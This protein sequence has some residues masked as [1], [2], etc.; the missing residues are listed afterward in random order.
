METQDRKTKSTIKILTIVGIVLILALIGSLVYFFV[1]K[2][3]KGEEPDLSNISCGCY[4]VDPAVTN[5][6]VGPSRG[7]YFKLNT[8][9]SDKVCSAQCD[10]NDIKDNLLNTSTPK[11]DFVSCPVRT[12][13]DTRCENII[14]KD[15]NDKII[16]GRIQPGDEI[17]A[18]AIFEKST[19]TDYVFIINSEDTTPDQVTGNKITKKIIPPSDKSSIEISATAKDTKGDRINSSITCR[20]VV[21]IE[22]SATTAV[23][24]MTA[25]TEQQSDGKTKITN[26]SISVGQINSSNIQIRFTFEPE[27]PTLQAVDGITVDSLKGSLEMSKLDLY[28]PT[29]FK[30]NSFNVLNDHLGSLKIMAEVF[31][32]EASIGSTETTITFSDS[33]TTQPP[34]EQPITDDQKS[35]FTVAKTVSPACVERVAGE[36]SATYTITINNT[37]TA[38]DSL[39]SIKDKLPLGFTYV[40]N[41]SVING[42]ATPDSGLVTVN[43]IGDSQEIIWEPTTPYTLASGGTMTIVFQANATP[44][45]TTGQN[46]NEVILNPIEI[47][48]DPATLRTQVYVVVAQDCENPTE[49]ETEIPQTGIFDNFITRILLGIFLLVI[50]WMVY[51]RPAG[52]LLSENILKSKIYGEYELTKYKFINPK[53]YFEEKILRK[54]FKGKQ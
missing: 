53:K 38:A 52:D 24:G 14:L 43:Q 20:R 2:D 41:S 16:T 7:F 32:N 37:K 54:R 30:E 5:D 50:G 26:I 36:D 27:F 35:S 44:T 18:E 3:D 39:T 15:Q 17:N 51:T 6:C 11:E 45:A 29:N 25:L 31:V 28:E 19:Y 34:I 1:L 21:E 12:I 9:S 47:P 8:V 49:E 42:T 23:T 22:T 40:V 10:G 33:S 46:L 13:S 48:L 4:L